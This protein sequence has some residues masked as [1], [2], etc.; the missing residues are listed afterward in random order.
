MIVRAVAAVLGLAAAFALAADARL[1]HLEESYLDL[2]EMRD[3]I[4]VSEARGTQRLEDGT[5]IS[6]ARAEFRRR[7]GALTQSLV[8][9]DQ[10]DLA[11]SDRQALAV[12]RRALRAHLAPVDEAGEKPEASSCPVD[13]P[14]VAKTNGL[15]GLQKAIYSCYGRAAEAIAF[16]GKTYDRLSVLE[17]LSRDDDASRRKALF[18]A[19]DP[20]FRTVNG[21]G[22]P[23]SPYRVMM[24]LSAEKWAR[25]GSPIDANVKALG[26]DPQKLEPWLVSILEAWRGLVSGDP[27]EPWD[28]GFVHGATGRLLANRV[29]LERLRPLNDT[30]YAALGADLA[31]LGVR[32]DLEPR[33]G[34]TPVAFCDFG[35][36]P[37]LRG[38][39]WT[40]GQPT[41][42][43]TYRTGGLGN[44]GELL[45]ESGHAI[46]IAA[47]RTR[48]AFTDWPDSDAF[49]EALGDLVALETHEPEWQR[50]NL[51]E[52]ATLEDN[53]RAKY[54]AVMLDVA[55]ALMEW[56]LHRD[57]AKDPN[58]VWTEITSRFL[59][60]KSHPATS[61]WARRGQLINAP[62][63]MM[64][65]A[66]GAILIADIRARARE[67]RGPL[68]SDPGYYG[69]LS[70]RLYRFGL[71]RS[72][73]DVIRDFLGRPPSPEALLAD[74]RRAA[75]NPQR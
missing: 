3:R 28:Y 43:A 12:M 73:G 18:R 61:W 8:G 65:Y 59:G 31:K 30:V 69:W 63:Y 48:P 24:P 60:I 2:F 68:E 20:L 14:A 32:Y 74:L 72:S 50:R 36:R 16:E 11:A 38:G 4:A 58:A 40:T 22:G 33:P 7:H 25:D 29:P 71:E 47:I 64:N 67:L 66:I 49:T 17:M 34:K 6:A 10:E 9:L 42:F 15:D 21:D 1:A 56:R 53:L 26:I 41:V 62:G 52:S 55:W 27:V 13:A 44:L 5:M 54:S 70:E 45:H 37:R 57:P 46:H 19:M 23:G 51:G 39:M 35:A 75:K